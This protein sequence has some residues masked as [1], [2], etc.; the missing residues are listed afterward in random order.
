MI[1][2]FITVVSGVLA[3]SMACYGEPATDYQ[4]S[5]FGS[6]ADADRDCLNTRHEILL[7]TSRQKPQFSASGCRVHSG[8]WLDPYTN[9]YLY[10]AEQIDIDH[11]VPLKWAWTHGAWR[12]PK[13]KLHTFANDPINLIGVSSS[14]NRSKG[15]SGPLQW[16]PE[17]RRFHCQYISR[18]LLTVAKYQLQLSATEERAINALL[19]KHC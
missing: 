1:L 17:N 12:W 10:R 9:R 15:A 2:R 18:F 7:E 3:A 4:R 8:R 5:K 16:L 19:G 6:W 13:E 14:A 11:L